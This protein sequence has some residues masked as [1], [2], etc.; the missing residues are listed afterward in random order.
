VSSVRH[1]VRSPSGAAELGL[2]STGYRGSGECRLSDRGT[3]Q[4]HGWVTGPA[5]E[6][7]D[8]RPLAA[9]LA[10]ELEVRDLS[11]SLLGLVTSPHPLLAAVSRAALLKLGLDVRRVGALDELS[12]FVPSTELQQIRAWASRAAA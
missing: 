6:G 8:R 9:V 10:A 12:E 7:A 1:L 4:L 5:G 3:R 2:L 11:R